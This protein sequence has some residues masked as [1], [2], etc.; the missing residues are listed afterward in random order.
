MSDPLPTLR[1]RLASR[2]FALT[3]GVLVVLVGLSWLAADRIVG[4]RVRTSAEDYL[5]TLTA[6]LSLATVPTDPN[7][8][9][10]ITEAGDDRLGQVVRVSDGSV[11]VSRVGFGRTPLIDPVELPPGPGGSATIA[12]PVAGEGEM[13]VDWAIVRFGDEDYVVYAGVSGGSLRV[14]PGVAALTALAALVAA[15]GVGVGV[16]LAV[17]SALRPVDALAGKADEIA[18][19]SHATGWSLDVTATTSEIGHLIERLDSLLR[20]VHESQERERSFL[21]DASHDLRTPIAVA[22]A[23]LDLAESTTMERGTRDSLL[24]AIEELDRLD[25]LAADLLILAKVRATPTREREIVH[26]GRL[27]RSTAARMVRNR[28]TDH[29]TVTVDGN[30]TAIGDPSTLERAIDNVVVNA[31]RHAAELVDISIASQGEGLV[32]VTIRDDGPGFPPELLSSATERFTSA[33]GRGEG[34]GLG[35]AIAEAIVRGH[36]G[37]LRLDNAIGGGGVVTLALPGEVSSDQSDH[38]HDGT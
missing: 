7:V 18:A 13:L 34:T 36:G 15:G 29:V 2:A 38:A 4:Q 5:Q 12:D 33:E 14:G 21:E 10:A 25:R 1:L 20:R 28:Q 22:R 30:G 6:E 9:A 35:L 17:Q 23:E 8:A 26:L 37:W 27:V 24:S 31:I 32:S 19:S 3:L 16:F 11:V